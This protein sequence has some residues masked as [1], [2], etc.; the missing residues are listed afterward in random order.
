[1]SCKYF[2]K[3]VFF[4]KHILNVLKLYT[5]ILKIH[6]LRKLLPKKRSF[7]STRRIE[8]KQKNYSWR[9]LLLCDW[10]FQSTLVRV[11]DPDPILWSQSVGSITLLILTK[12]QPGLTTQFWDISNRNVSLSLAFFHV[13][14]PDQNFICT[15]D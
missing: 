10:K 11:F 2:K 15:S 3:N 9:N 5:N 6:T 13:S 1:M 4:K 14:I 8:C 12:I 7:C